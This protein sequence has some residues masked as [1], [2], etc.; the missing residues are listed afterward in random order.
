MVSIQRT[1][2]EWNI[3]SVKDKELLNLIVGRAGGKTTTIILDNILD[4]PKNKNQLAKKLNYDYNTIS[5][6]INLLDKHNYIIAKK[7]DNSTYYH[8]SKK[9]FNHLPEYKQLREYVLKRDE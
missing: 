7:L 4:G 8:P 3:W 1:L 5:Y 6:H 2:A 9:L